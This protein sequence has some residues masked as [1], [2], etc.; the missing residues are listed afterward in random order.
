LHARLS[1][2]PGRGHAVSDIARLTAAPE[3]LCL[4][5]AELLIG[6]FGLYCLLVPRDSVGL[7]WLTLQRAGLLAGV[8]GI[9]SFA[10]GLYNHDTYRQTRRLV[11]VTVIAGVLS[12]VAVLAVVCA[13]GIVPELPLRRTLALW[14][15]VLVLVRLAFAAATRSGWFARRM[16]VIGTDPEAERLLTAL[17]VDR[18]GLSQVVAQLPVDA[19]G[20]D[21]IARLPR[22]YG[23][24]VT[25]AAAVAL[26]PGATSRLQARGLALLSGREFWECRLRRI[27]VEQEGPWHDDPA[28]R[29]FSPG[30]I[31]HRGLD[32]M[33]SLVLLIA[34]APLLLVTAIAVRLESRGPILYRQQRVGLHGRIFTVLK[35]RSMRAD[36]EALGPVWA[37][38]RDP[39]VTRVGALIRLVRLDEVPQVYNVLRGDMSFIGPRPERPHFTSQLERDLPHYG[40]RLLV[41]PGLTGWAQ[42]NYPYGASVE[43]ARAKL[44]YDLYYV[45]HRTMLLDILILF[46]TVRVVL[47]Q[48]GAR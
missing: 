30:D 22:A 40:D 19:F 43:D 45:K 46:A 8:I 4:V 33:L 28:G 32:L 38:K 48:S 11:A 27:D 16:I 15:F 6:T 14:L 24:V 18:G 17:R 29:P 10:V 2:S 20:L 3:I 13:M 23:V 21:A 26:T 25:R 41:K 36:A 42:V 34:T 44:S 1:S 5:L 47:F 35:F 12:F 7:D 9:V 39:R 31:G 37:S